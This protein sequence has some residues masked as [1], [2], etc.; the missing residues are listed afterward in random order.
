MSDVLDGV[1]I[2]YHAT[3]LTEAAED[4]TQCFSGRRI[5][6]SRP[7]NS[8]P[9]TNFT[10]AASLRPPSLPSWPGSRPTCRFLMLARA[11]AGRRA[12]CGSLR[13]PGCGRRPQRAIRGCRAHLT[14]RTGQGGQVS[15]QTASAL[16]LPFDDGRFN[17][18]L[19]QHVAMN[20]SDRARLY[21]EI[22]RVLKS[23]ASLRLRT[24][25]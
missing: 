3:G 7:S 24:S 19:L 25:C 12:F 5:N 10:P 2:H 4:G 8:V 17:V 16:E 9:S 11:L 18:V 13:L 20:I 22:R 6:A 23:V 14:E 21:R 1:R 15:F